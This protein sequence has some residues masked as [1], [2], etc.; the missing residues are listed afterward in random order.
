MLAVLLKKTENMRSQSKEL[1][2]Y[3]AGLVTLRRPAGLDRPQ[4]ALNAGSGHVDTAG[5]TFKYLATGGTGGRQTLAERI[6]T[7]S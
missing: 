1:G 5:V 4:K 6:G 7:E 3:R 2:I